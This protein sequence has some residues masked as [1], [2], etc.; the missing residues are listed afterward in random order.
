MRP[1]LDESAYYR[2]CDDPLGQHPFTMREWRRDF[3]LGPDHLS[4]NRYNTDEEYDEI[5]RDRIAD[6]DIVLISELLR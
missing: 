3:R 5:F 1:K 6:G 4:E 2:Y